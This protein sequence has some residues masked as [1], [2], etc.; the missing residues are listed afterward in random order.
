[1]PGT[2]VV[3]RLTIEGRIEGN[4]SGRQG[5]MFLDWLKKENKLDYLQR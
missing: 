5:E 3:S 4:T 2:C 1:M